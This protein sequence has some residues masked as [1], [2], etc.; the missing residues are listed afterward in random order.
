MVKH[1]HINNIQKPV[2]QAFLFHH[3]NFYARQK[4]LDFNNVFS[5]IL[6]KLKG[7]VMN[8]KNTGMFVIENKELTINALNHVEGALKRS[9]NNMKLI[10]DNKSNKDSIADNSFNKQSIDLKPIENS[11]KSNET[12]IDLI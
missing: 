8:N 7:A 3:K 5:L 1:K 11:I 6:D 9:L 10:N 2:H 4:S 12:S